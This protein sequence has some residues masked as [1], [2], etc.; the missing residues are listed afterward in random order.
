M[1]HGMME[2]G[3]LHPS[4]LGSALD[5]H[6]NGKKDQGHYGHGLGSYNPA[7]PYGEFPEYSGRPSKQSAPRWEN[8]PY[9]EEMGLF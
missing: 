3:P 8:Q 7:G 9:M 1:P 6:H 5:H 2:T 4:A